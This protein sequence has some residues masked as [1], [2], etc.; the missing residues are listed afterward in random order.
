MGFQHA[1]TDPVKLSQD[2]D[3]EQWIYGLLAVGD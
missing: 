3:M 2:E 1:Y